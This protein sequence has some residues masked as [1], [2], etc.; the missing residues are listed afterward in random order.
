MTKDHFKSYVAQLCKTFAVVVL[1]VRDLCPNCLEESLC[2]A[3]SFM[4][5]LPHSSDRRKSSQDTSV[6][7]HEKRSIA[8]L[9]G[10][11]WRNV[12]SRRNKNVEIIQIASD[13]SFASSS[14]A[15]WRE[16]SRSSS[17]L[18]ISSTMLF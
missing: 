12:H 13:V 16:C 7:F 17:K 1:Q 11:L 14:A 10:L 5:D 9:M 3:R 6:A 2:N 8:E 4:N 18:R 15:R